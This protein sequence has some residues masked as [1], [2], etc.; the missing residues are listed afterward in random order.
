[1]NIREK[2]AVELKLD[3]AYISRIAD[4]SFCYYKD[5]TIP[6]RNGMPRNISQPSPELKTLQY[7]VVHNILCKLPVSSAASAYKKGDSIKKN[8]QLHRHSEYILHADIRSFFP[9]I[10]ASMLKTLLRSNK[11]IF[12]DMGLDLEESLSDI[13]AICFRNGVL[14]I[15]S[16]SSPSISNIV[17]YSFDTTMLEY[18]RAN[19]YIY[20]R[21]AD[22]IYI[23][24]KHYINPSVLA[25]LQN[26]LAKYNFKLNDSKTR[27]SSSK[28]RRKVT[29]LVITNDSQISIGTERRNQIKK[30][31]YDK[32]IH[33][34]GDSNQILG[35]LSFLKDVEP[36]TYNNIIIK[37]SQYCDGDLIK[38]LSK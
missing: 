32:L 16:V 38:E 2:I 6:K 22:D 27:F 8:A 7:W 15:G 23:S 18:C 29:G 35:Y 10:R 17:M 14:C 13:Q 5:Y 26:E 12:D 25:F 28:S 31:V 9:S 1:M 20:S 21:Y 24:S 19:E 36:R 33:G 34:R 4:R 37:Y 11:A 3:L 30:M